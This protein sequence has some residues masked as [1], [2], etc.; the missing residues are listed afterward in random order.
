MGRK[1]GEAYWGQRAR[2]EAFQLEMLSVRA[3]RL[4]AT[5]MAAKITGELVKKRFEGFI[6]SFSMRICLLN[7]LSRLYLSTLNSR[8]TRQK[9][10]YCETND[11]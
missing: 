2:I 3:I 8:T 4:T 6:L 9:W 1:V 10:T 5:H 7:K 11:P